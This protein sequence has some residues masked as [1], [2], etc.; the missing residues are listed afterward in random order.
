MGEHPRLLHLVCS[1]LPQSHALLQPFI[2]SSY[3]F[4]AQHVFVKMLRTDE[5]MY[6]SLDLASFLFIMYA[7]LRCI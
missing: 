1:S 5:H 6:L 3:H 4:A 7:L 2:L